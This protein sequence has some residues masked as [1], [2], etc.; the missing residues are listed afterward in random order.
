MAAPSLLF[1]EVDISRE[2]FIIRARSF[3]GL[4]YTH[5]KAWASN[6]G[7]RVFGH[8]DC[9]GFPLLVARECGMLPSDFPCDLPYPIFGKSREKVLLEI[10]ALNMTKISV[11]EAIPGDILFIG[12]PGVPEHERGGRHIAFLSNDTPRPLGSILHSWC[13]LRGIGSV[14]EQR[15]TQVDYD[16]VKSAYRLKLWITGGGA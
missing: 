6:I 2:E 10:I 12:Y 5:G 3:I 8:C 4:K 11:E 13:D 16:C 15:L 7:G 9:A 14:F 1:N